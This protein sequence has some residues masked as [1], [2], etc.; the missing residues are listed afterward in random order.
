MSAGEAKQHSEVDPGP[1]AGPHHDPLEPRIPQVP[2]GSPP[3]K[4]LP[5]NTR[6]SFPAVLYGSLRVNPGIA[7]RSKWQKGS[8]QYR[9]LR[10][11][12]V[13]GKEMDTK[14]PHENRMLNNT[15]KNM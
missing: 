11:D 8:Q 6:S 1:A 5:Q 9:T 2:P 13:K 3:R 7:I 14:R 15:Y 12:K 10:R 4:Q